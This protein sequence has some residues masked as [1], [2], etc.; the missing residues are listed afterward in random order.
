MRQSG[1]RRYY[2][3]I[4]TVPRL[5][6][7]LEWE[8]RTVAWN[9]RGE[10]PPL[11]FLH[12]T[13]WSSALWGPIGDALAGRFSVYLWDMPGYGASSK[14][15]DHAVDLGVQGELFAHLLAEWGLQR[16]HVIA[17][18]FGGA[19]SLRARLLHDVRYASLCLVDVV[20]L[21]PWGSPF[22]TL[23][24]QNA[25]AFAQLPSA[26][27]RGAVEAYIRGASYR[28]LSDDDLAMLVNPWIG[29]SGQPAF[30]RQIAQADEGFTAEIE[31]MLG[32]I[33]EPTHIVWGTEDAW[34]PSDRASR[35]HDVMPGSTLRLVEHA[36]HLIQLDAPALL[37]AELVGWTESVRAIA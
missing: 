25:E 37:A 22:F 5:S 13:P 27:H 3:D 14:E 31:P 8:G 10:G 36:G 35:L 24:R 32:S 26:V 30:Y 15:P 19:V 21:R 29:D 6:R 33:D 11:V 23:V 2:D 9:R 7:T 1:A 4:V 34:I 20:A 16:P 12:G 28:G 17:H 18:D